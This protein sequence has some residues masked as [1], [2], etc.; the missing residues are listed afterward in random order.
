[1]LANPGKDMAMSK[2]RLKWSAEQVDAFLRQEFPQAYRNGRD[3][4]ISELQPGVV[5]VSF[6]AGEDQLR[7]GGTV[8]GPAL[9]ELVDFSVYALLVGHHKQSARLSVTTNLQ[10]SFL[11][12]ADPGELVCTAEL[13]KHGRTLSV[14]ASRIVHAASGRLI[15]HSEATYYMA[16]AE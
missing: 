12:K 11:R 4:R 7:P 2:S 1:M 13:I 15:A 16:D 6:V 10:I 14:A 8:S 9:M 5:A 3:Y